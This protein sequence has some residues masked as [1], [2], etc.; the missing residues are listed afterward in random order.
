MKKLFQTRLAGL[1]GFAACVPIADASDYFHPDLLRLGTGQAVSADYLEIFSDS[2][3]PPGTYEVTLLVNNKPAQTREVTFLLRNGDTR[4]KRLFPCLQPEDLTS[5]GIALPATPMV[6]LDNRECLDLEALDYLS[7][8]FD[9]K[10]RALSLSVPQSYFSETLLRHAQEKLW[11]EGI[12]NFSMNYALNAFKNSGESSNYYANLRPG[13]NLGPWRYRNYSTWSKRGGIRHWNTISNTVSRDLIAL[14]SELSL[15][16]SYTSAAL[17]DAYKFRG[18]KLQ[19]NNLMTPDNQR[20]YVPAI[21]GLVSSDAQI[22]VTQNGNVVYQNTVPA[23]PFNI[24]DYYPASYGGDLDVSIQEA[25][26]SVRNFIVPFATVPIL[27]KKG[28]FKYAVMSGKYLGESTLNATQYV[29]QVELIYGVSEYQTLYGGVQA[30]QKYKAAMLGLGSNLGMLGAVAAD[31]TLASSDLQQLGRHSGRAVRF[32][33]AKGFTSTGTSISITNRY[34]LDE[35]Y[36]T[37]RDA[38]HQYQDEGRERNHLN[39]SV[40]Q[41]LPGRLGSLS[42]N[43]SY[44]RFRDQ[45]HTRSYN[46]G[47]QGSYNGIAYALFYQKFQNSNRRYFNNVNDF[48][49]YGDVGALN[50]SQ[51]SFNISIPLSRS[52]S[53]LWTNYSVSRTNDNAVNQTLHINGNAADNRVAWGAYQGHGNKGVSNYG[54]VNALYRSSVGDINAAYSYASRGAN[55]LSYGMSGAVT[56]TEYGPVLSQQLH[57]SNA[58]IVAPDADGVRIK[59]DPHSTTDGAGMAIVSGLSLYRNNTITLDTATLPENV[60]LDS[61]VVTNLFPTNGALLLSRFKTQTGYKI[62]FVIKNQEIPSGAQ[63]RLEGSEQR[64][65]AS[66]FNQLYAIAPQPSGSVTISWSGP[67]NSGHA[68][69]IDFDLQDQ[70]ASNGLYLV[71]AECAR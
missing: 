26:G 8:Y 60:E 41:P 3:I 53:A 20:S 57:G 17:F 5:L 58:L 31:L 15:G 70:A 21:T 30:T 9:W 67:Q 43:T 59:N 28:H 66:N 48:N 49:D 55:N 18:A 50:S 10:A 22:T 1:L 13:F 69:R 34:Y 27:E 54:G 16:D 24:T 56:V 6:S 29:S 35:N 37:L 63:A 71:D 40:T 38:I 2:D 44:Y 65:T 36:R 7:Y 12:P 23:G 47:Y 32:N 42:M 51:V 46:I 14:R 33:Y 64:F 4:K 25:D 52:D 62:L 45:S 68:C 39:L 11:S 19:S 61:T